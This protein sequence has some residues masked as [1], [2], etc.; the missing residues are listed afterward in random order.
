MA[1]AARLLTSSLLAALVPATLPALGAADG[2]INITWDTSSPVFFQPLDPG[3]VTKG[4]LQGTVDVAPGVQVST[5]TFFTAHNDQG[6]ALVACFTEEFLEFVA[7]G[8]V[9]AFSG[10]IVE[11]SVSQATLPG[12]YDQNPLNVE[13]PF[14]YLELHDDLLGVS[15]GPAGFEVIV[16]DQ[17]PPLIDL[18]GDGVVNGSDLGLLLGNWGCTGVGCIGD[19]NDDGVVDGADLGMLLGGWNS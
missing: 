13:L 6:E 16:V 17:F 1:P 3:A 5:Y 14:P 4:W 8:S 10:P 11:F 9:G 18:N 19:L 7:E 2:S 12:L 15:S